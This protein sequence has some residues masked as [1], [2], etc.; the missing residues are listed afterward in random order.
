MGFETNNLDVGFTHARQEGAGL[1]VAG[2]LVIAE[3]YDIKIQFA[4]QLVLVRRW[5]AQDGAIYANAGLH[6][7]EALVLLLVG[8]TVFFRADAVVR[9]NDHEYWVTKPGGLRKKVTVTLMQ[10]IKCPKRYYGH[11]PASVR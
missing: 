1:V 9:G 8:L 5:V 4:Q 7:G 11:V 2:Q 6:G 3:R 10:W